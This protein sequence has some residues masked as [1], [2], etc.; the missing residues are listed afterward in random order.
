M[1]V[2]ITPELAGTALKAASGA[3]SGL[4]KTIGSFVGGRARRREQRR[5]KRD[6]KRQ[7]NAYKGLDTSNLA[8]GQ[9]NMY[10]DLTVNTQQ[11]NFVAQQQQ[12]GLANVMTQ[13][14]A[15]AGTS[16]IGI[17]AQSLANQQS[18]N[19]V[20]SAMSIGEQERQNQ[21]MSMGEASRI[22][23]AEIAGAQ[24]AR[25]LEWD[26][27]ET[28]LGMAGQRLASAN[29]ARQDATA[30]TFS[31]LG[32]MAGGALS[33]GQQGMLGKKIQGALDPNEL[34]RKQ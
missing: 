32:D 23:S 7:M 22:Q 25:T 20:N 9:Q 19:M 34:F 2:P 15:A 30:A 3:A 29:Q 24:Q 18:L 4:F 14:R 17:L 16:G 11:A 27:T 5:A 26:R 8:L 31:G 21:L 1:A 13:N 10:E 12:Q 33:A 28:L 6:Y